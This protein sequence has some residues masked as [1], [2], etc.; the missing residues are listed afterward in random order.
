[1]NLHSFL[2]QA[3]RDAGREVDAVA[4]YLNVSPDMIYRYESG[5]SEPTLSTVAKMAE[6]YGQQL[7]DIFPSAKP[8]SREL[9]PLMLALEDFD[10]EERPSVVEKVTRDL[11]FLAMLLKGRT[12]KVATSSPEPRRS[13]TV[14]NG[15]NVTTFPTVPRWTPEFPVEPTEFNEGGDF[16]YPRIFHGAI[17]EDVEEAAAGETGILAEDTLPKTTVLHSRHVFDETLRVVKV[18]GDSMTPEFEAGWLLEVDLKQ[19][20]PF[21][22]DPVA[23]YR[24]DE[25]GIIGWFQRLPDGRAQLLKENEA[26]S[27]VLIEETDLLLGVITDVLKKP[28][29]RKRINA[30]PKKAGGRA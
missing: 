21:D 7:G 24:K 6:C 14:T 29:R 18:K 3:R 19:K 16:D 28:V 12:A 13:Q 23:I 26:Y 9:Q 1:V 11:S 22:G 5:R 8:R 2:K 30:K 20:R 15:E 25:G 10:A 27:P 17:I 4:A